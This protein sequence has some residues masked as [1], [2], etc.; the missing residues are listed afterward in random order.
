[1][2]SKNVRFI[3]IYALQALF[4]NQAKL[5]FASLQQSILQPFR[6]L[7]SFS[8]TLWVILV[9]IRVRSFTVSHGRDFLVSAWVARQYSI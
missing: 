8:I 3:P 1:M 5:R 9:Q 4:S 2:W 6:Q 7:P